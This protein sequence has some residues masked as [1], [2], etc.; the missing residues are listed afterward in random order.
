M[1]IWCWDRFLKEGGVLF[2]WMIYNYETMFDGD[3]IKHFDIRYGTYSV[4]DS[5]EEV[6]LLYGNE[7]EKAL[8]PWINN[9]YQSGRLFEKTNWKP[10]RD[11][12]LL[13]R[14]YFGY[15]YSFNFKNYYLQLAL[16]FA[17]GICEYCK[18]GEP[19]IHFE[20]ALY[21]WKE[22]EKE[23]IQ[24]DDVVPIPQDNIIPEWYWDM[25]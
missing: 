23:N 7:I 21:G 22:P 15:K 20:V 17:C 11:Q 24:P 6:K 4:M 19:R 2:D 10:F 9:E 25:N 14:M 16:E 12:Y 3:K 18:K 13:T 5:E 8:I 1:S